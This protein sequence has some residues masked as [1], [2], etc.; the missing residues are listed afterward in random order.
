MPDDHNPREP[1]FV[2]TFFPDILTGAAARWRLI[3]SG[4]AGFVLVVSVSFALRA[5]LGVVGRQIHHPDEIF[6]TIEQAHRFVF[7]FGI[8]P[9]EY[10]EGIRWLGTPLLLTPP[11][12]AAAALGQGPEFYIPVLRVLLA[13]FSLLPAVL[14]FRIA[15]EQ[16]GDGK[17]AV[18]AVL[19]L[20]WHENLYFSTI[21]L[22]DSIAAVPF[23][24][25]AMLPL[26]FRP[27]TGNRR[28]AA[29]AFLCAL[30]FAMRFHLAPALAFVFIVAL[31]S[32]T[33]AQRKVLIVASAACALALAALDLVFGAYPFRHIYLNFSRNIFDGVAATFGTEPWYFYPVMIWNNAGLAML[34]VIAVLITA[35]R[36][37]WRL[38]LP[39]LIVIGCFSLIG[40][41]EYRFTYPATLL[42]SFAAA[43]SVLELQA[44]Y[45]AN[46]RRKLVSPILVVAAL[47]LVV[48]AVNLPRYRT[49]LTEREDNIATASLAASHRED[50]CGLAWIS[51]GGDIFFSGGYAYFHRDVPFEAFKPLAFGESA[52]NRFNYALAHPLYALVLSG[53]Y[54]ID[55]CWSLGHSAPV[56]LLRRPGGCR[57]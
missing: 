32:L 36:W 50:I 38:V 16:F 14:F 39:A 5:Y 12:L 22:S 26:T 43:W 7:G 1:A 24:M 31:I 9:W 46:D 30:T 15:R 13:A 51:N 20:F 21:T 19:P 47:V 23:A 34:L 27:E 40:H 29:F 45:R 35:I 48:I 44:R 8:L 33:P 41:K 18:A 54:T 28:I 11:F 4:A 42:L 53:A 17:A 49:L 37:Q 57:G 56:C 3:S 10:H 55:T 25:A 2:K 6:Q 52:A